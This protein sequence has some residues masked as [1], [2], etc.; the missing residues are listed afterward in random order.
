[1][2][3]ATFGR[4]H[5]G[6]PRP[7]RAAAVAGGGR[8][9]RR[10]H[11]AAGRPSGA[12][13]MRP[14]RVGGVLRV[15]LTGGIGSGKSTVA[16]RFAELGAVLVDSDV[17]A[18]EVVAP[19]HR[20]SRRGRH[21]FGDGVLGADGALDRPA[22][23]AVVFGDPRRARPA[24]RD[25]APA[26]AAAHG[27][28]GRPRARGQ[29]RGA[30]RPAARRRRDGGAFAL[31]VVVHADARER[32]RRLVESRGMTEADAR[33]RIAAQAAERPPRRGGR[34]ARQLRS[35][36]GAA[37]A[38]DALWDHRLV[39]FEDN[40]ADRD[41][42]R[43]RRDPRRP[44]PASG[45][46][47]APGSR[48]G[49]PGGRVRGRD[50]AHVGPT[51]V[52]GLSAVDVV[53]LQ[54]GVGVAP[55]TP[56]RCAGRLA[57]AG[58]ARTGPPP[59]RAAAAGADP[60]RPVRLVLRPAGR[61][62]WR[63]P[64]VAGLA[65]GGR[66]G[67]GRRTRGPGRPSR[68]P[69]AC[70]AERRNG[71]H[72]RGGR[73]RWRSCRD[74][75][76]P[77]RSPALRDAAMVNTGPV[78]RW[79]GRRGHARRNRHRRGIPG[80]HGGPCTA[81]RDGRSRVERRSG[82]RRGERAG[83][84]PGRPPDDDVPAAPSAEADATRQPTS[85]DRRPRRVDADRS[86]LPTLEPVSAGPRSSRTRPRPPRL[87]CAP[88]SAPT[89]RR[90]TSGSSPSS[91][92]SR[93]TRRRRTRSCRRRTRVPGGSWADG[94]PS[95]DPTGWVRRVAVR[96]TIAVGARRGSRSPRVPSTG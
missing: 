2:P 5:A 87:S 9:P 27:R 6:R 95:A 75:E 35:T 49:S 69:E 91:T 37:A 34:R 3:P 36:R 81:W 70:I 53:D 51:A 11:R 85:I 59:R 30:G 25:R 29:R 78:T 60:G 21:A 40:L 43:P 12:A 4:G 96:S 38:V 80:A 68:T 72:R 90:T 64:A 82:G 32:V 71:P 58:F 15:G 56:A 55:P 94:R 31:V 61:P 67:P 10:S 88:T 28:A 33:A 50:V 74:R 86:R 20:G 47:R 8:S 39:P 83:R 13:P 24:Q 93:S 48:P 41:R 18:R 84:P 66:R 73:R 1:M 26:G 19:G 22:L 92:P 63:R 62:A 7:A 54:V 79:R 65:A 52:P 76:R 44:G 17:L 16:R 57:A 77:R 23:A 14:D 46:R 42:C 89:S 45:R